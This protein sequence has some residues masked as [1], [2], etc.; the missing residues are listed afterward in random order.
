MQTPDHSRR[1]GRA[2]IVAGLLIAVAVLAAANL[3]AQRAV[4]PL[5]AA[6]ALLVTVVAVAVASR[7]FARARRVE[8]LLREDNRRWAMA[9]QA[10]RV[11]MFEWDP[12]SDRLL[13]HRN[14]SAS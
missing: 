8:R 4:A 1:P 3:L 14:S 2:A 5:S 9:A 10:A 13:W 11:E 12:A 7:A 6:L